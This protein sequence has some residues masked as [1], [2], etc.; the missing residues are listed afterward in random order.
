MSL[1]PSLQNCISLTLIE[2]LENH[3]PEFLTLWQEQIILEQND[4]HK[5]KVKENGYFMYV[6]IKK[7]LLDTISDTEVQKLAYKVAQERVDANINIGDFVYNVNIGRSILITF[8]L[9]SD[10]T[11]E[12]LNSIINK[13]NAQFDRFCYFAVT[14]YTEIKNAE[15]EEKNVFI[16]Q[17]HNDK[18]TILGQ[19]SS[20]FVH[21]F[22]NPLTSIIGFN[23]I[24]RTE[25]PNLKYLDIIELELDQLKFRITQFLHTSKMS[26]VDQPK[27]QVKVSQLLETILELLYPS[28]IDS[29]VQITTEF[30][31]CIFINAHKDELKQVFLN[32]LF[33]SI[34][35][36]QQR[37]ASRKI[38]IKCYEKE[39]Q[40]IIE[41]ANNGPM[42][43]VN[44]QET[45]F[46]PF[47]TTKELG[48]GIGLFVCKKI[49]EK[50]SGNLTYYSDESLTTFY[51]QLPLNTSLST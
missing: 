23:K 49:I 41:V 50:H 45:I 6:L 18:L 27:E 46:E 3:E 11:G 4:I 28:I 17:S 21:E 14:R 5:E 33:N 32:V 12:P 51:I 29:D 2:F 42:I 34:D 13:I 22:R 16:N 35:A 43:P 9:K 19:M 48:T 7:T 47:Y 36:V 15:L 20:S 26:L 10:I 24:L 44:V 40:V 31:D 1:N 8:V 25:Y 39:D 38:Y 37:N 30:D